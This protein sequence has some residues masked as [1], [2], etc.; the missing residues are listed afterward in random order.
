MMVR[1]DQTSAKHVL[2]TAVTRN[3]T[4]LAERRQDCFCRWSQSFKSGEVV[5]R[6]RFHVIKL[7]HLFVSEASTELMSVFE[8]LE[9]RVSIQMS[10]S[11]SADSNP[12]QVA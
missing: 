3:Q 10:L 7:R 1:S 9:T 2:M 11:L 12:G 4:K 6:S 5:V 8:D